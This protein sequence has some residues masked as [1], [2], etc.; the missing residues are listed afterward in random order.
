MHTVRSIAVVVAALA[1]TT[2]AWADEPPLPKSKAAAT[3]A[4]AD[5]AA[6]DKAAAT[7]A[8]ADKT[9]AT[10]AAGDK[11]AA[12][13]T[14]EPTPPPGDQPPATKPATTTPAATKGK[15][16]KRAKKYRSKQRIPCEHG[17]A[18][19]KWD[20]GCESEF[21]KD[22]VWQAQWKSVMKK[23]LKPEVHETEARRISTNNKHVV[24][25][26]AGLWIIVVGFLVMMFLR[27]GKLQNEIA[28]LESELKKAVD[29]G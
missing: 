23:D 8:A 14:A 26:Y 11:A 5:T 3:K 20:G 27:Q 16:G 18:M 4:A 6:K 9:A 1:L 19:G 25:A 21:R 28:R 2:T 17:L 24:M 10:K 29:E 7:N 22:K 13:K 12:G 15:P